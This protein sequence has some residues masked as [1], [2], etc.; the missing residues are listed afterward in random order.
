VTSLLR[1]FLI[2]LEIKNQ[3]VMSHALSIAKYCG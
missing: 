1:C 2:C 3:K